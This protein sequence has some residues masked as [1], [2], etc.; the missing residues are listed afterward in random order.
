MQRKERGVGREKGKKIK[1]SVMFFS[2]YSIVAQIRARGG[3]FQS[4][5]PLLSCVSSWRKSLAATCKFVGKFESLPRLLPSPS[6][7]EK[8]GVI[9]VVGA[10]G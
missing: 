1:A 6:R 5:R 3:G 9:G 2:L 10:I 7:E 4:L 8:Q